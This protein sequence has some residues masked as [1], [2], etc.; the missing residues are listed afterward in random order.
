[1]KNKGNMLFEF[2]LGT[3]VWIL[4]LMGILYVSGLV[5]TKWA[6]LEVG[7][8]GTD[9]QASSN[10]SE[11]EIRRLLSKQIEMKRFPSRIQWTIDL[12]PPDSSPAY[13]FYKLVQTRVTARVPGPFS[14]EENVV[15]Q[16][17]TYE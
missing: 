2:L 14:I 6:A 7:E 4:C 3:S 13:H 17:E 15:A 12:R 9:L 8:L 11:E 5:L 10:L 16:K 1:M